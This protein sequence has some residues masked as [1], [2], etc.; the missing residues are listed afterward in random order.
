MKNS[1]ILLIGP[2]GAGKTTIGR[3]L[4]KNLGFLFLDTDKEIERKTGASIPLIFEYE[5]EVGF[6]KR[7]SE[8]IED[9]LKL[10]PIVLATGGGSVL[11]PEN[12]LRL[13]ASG[14]IVY[15]YCPVE[16]QL[17]RTHKDPNRPLLKTDN[18]Q[19]KLMELFEVRDPIYRQLADYVVD[20][21]LSSSRHVV[22]QIIKAYERKC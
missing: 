1:N 13:Q 3:L 11:L 21:G 15:L 12:R 17:E 18:P 5:G 2:M 4:A 22:K 10:E 9:L 19:K 16:K 7:E 6:R 20:T 14:F 8:V